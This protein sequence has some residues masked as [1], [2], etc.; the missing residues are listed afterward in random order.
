MP[1]LRATRIESHARVSACASRAARRVSRADPLHSCYVMPSQL[2]RDV[3]RAA[4]AHPPRGYSEPR[5]ASLELILELIHSSHVMPSHLVVSSHLHSTSTEPH[6]HPPRGADAVARGVAGPRV[7]YKLSGLVKHL[8]SNLTWRRWCRRT[9][10]RARIRRA[11]IPSRRA[12]LSRADPLMLYPANS[13][14]LIST[15]SYLPPKGGR[16]SHAASHARTLM[17]VSTQSIQHNS[18]HLVAADRSTR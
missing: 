15:S 8:Q 3:N 17:K 9:I 13:F 16:A 12:R 10:C 14:R 6:A 7:E 4:R 11:H 1:G 18:S 2:G 5:G